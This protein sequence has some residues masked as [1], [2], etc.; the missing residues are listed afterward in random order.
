MKEFMLL[1]RNEADSKSTF[2]A[3]QDKAFLN[4]CKVYIEKLQANGK[5]ISAQPLVREGKVISGSN[6][7][8][9]EAPYSLDKEVIVGYYH[10]R[11][12][13]LEEATSIAKGNPEF[14]FTTTARVEVRPIKMK[15]ESTAYVYPKG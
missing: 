6:G 15:E 4:A 8:W 11:A 2:S 9:S 5:L 13:N 12:N 7:S 3:D 14:E 10:I 1:I